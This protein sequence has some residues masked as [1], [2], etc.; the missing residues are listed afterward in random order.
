VINILTAALAAAA[1]QAPV[2]YPQRKSLRFIERLSFTTTLFL[3]ILF[4]E[5]VD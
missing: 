2:V 4:D 1:A 3:N 5:T